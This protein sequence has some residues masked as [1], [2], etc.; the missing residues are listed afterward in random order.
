MKF[1][2]SLESD[3]DF[4]TQKH[5]VTS[6]QKK[7]SEIAADV[8][9]YLAAFLIFISILI[10]NIEG[11]R[12]KPFFG[13]SFFTVVSNSMEDEIPKG[14]LILV[15][16]ISA[17]K[18][19]VGDN[20]TFAQN[21]CTLIAHK[22]IDI[23]K[24]ND[25]SGTA[26]FRTKGVNNLTPDSNIVNETDVIGKVIFVIPGL[27]T[28]I[29]FLNEKFYIIFIVLGLWITTYLVTSYNFR[30]ERRRRT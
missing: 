6:P 28:V 20:I 26:R 4:L 15:K 13:Y 12:P 10:F 9:F 3:Y 11:G 5:T 17:Q 16:S 24:D 8:M 29:S 14:S 2:K 21:R 1:K 7:I 25:N 23:Y 30:V 19:N 22:I 18:L 27:G